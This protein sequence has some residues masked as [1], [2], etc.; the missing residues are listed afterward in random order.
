MGKTTSRR[1]AIAKRGLRP[2]RVIWSPGWLAI[3]SDGVVNRVAELPCPSAISCVVITFIAL[4]PILEQGWQARRRC[5]GRDPR[6]CSLAAL[7]PIDEALVGGHHRYPRRTYFVKTLSKAANQFRHRVAAVNIA[8]VDQS[9]L[10][11]GVLEKFRRIVRAARLPRTNQHL[12]VAGA[13]LAA[14]RHIQAYPGI[15]VTDL[16]KTMAL[17]QST[18]SNLLDKLLV[19]RL[20]RRQRDSSDA[21][22]AHL[23]VTL[24]GERVLRNARFPDRSV[25]LETLERLPSHALRRLDDDLENVLR[26]IPSGVPRRRT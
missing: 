15:K 16:A 24:G 20:V 18:V 19:K 12:I 6:Y 23:T 17:H 9:T 21:R 22:I 11:A 26:H 14:L 25:L 5:P 2:P 4:C 1:C 13:P 7:A 10:A 3:A 8:P